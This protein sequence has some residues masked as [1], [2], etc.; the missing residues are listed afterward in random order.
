L[1]W[2]I[3]ARVVGV[4]VGAIGHGRRYLLLHGADRVAEDAGTVFEEGAGG[5]VEAVRSRVDVLLGGF[6]AS[7]GGEELILLLFGGGDL[8]EGGGGIAEF[9]LESEPAGLGL[10]AVC[11]GLL[12]LVVGQLR[13]R[14]IELVGTHTCLSSSTCSEERM[15]KS[16]ESTMASEARREMSRSSLV[17]RIIDDRRDSDDS[18]TDWDLTFVTRRERAGIGGGAASFNFKP[19]VTSLVVGGDVLRVR[20]EERDDFRGRL[21]VDDTDDTDGLRP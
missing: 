5:G 21:E 18:E 8:G 9:G 11:E 20:A 6:D 16:R 19:A 15:V 4:S 1:A 2:S 12:F 3:I 13:S 10:E 17:L 7:G 14:N